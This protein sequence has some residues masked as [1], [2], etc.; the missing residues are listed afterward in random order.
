MALVKGGKAESSKKHSNA[1]TCRGAES[2][3]T[4]A[5]SQVTGVP[6]NN[7]YRETQETN[8][9]TREHYKHTR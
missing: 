5:G 6:V 4:G 2:W 8:Q 9:I 1:V 3:A 7:E